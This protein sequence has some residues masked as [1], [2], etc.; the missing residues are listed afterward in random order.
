MK[1]KMERGIFILTSDAGIIR[2]A[3]AT[4]VI[5]C[6]SGH[7]TSTP[8]AMFIVAIVLGHWI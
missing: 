4:I 7:F 6:N 8:R 1:N 2:H 3:D 5:K